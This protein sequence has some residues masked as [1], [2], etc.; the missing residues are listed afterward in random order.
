LIVLLL[1]YYVKQ[2]AGKLVQKEGHTV[3]YV[4]WSVYSGYFESIGTITFWAMMAAAV[5]SI[6]LSLFSSVW[7]G[8]WAQGGAGSN[9]SV[10]FYISIYVALSISTVFFVY[11]S[12]ALGFKGAVAASEKMH[13]DF[14]HGLMRAPIS[15][16]DSTPL[17][18]ITNRLSKD[19]NQVDTVIMFNLQMFLRAALG[20]LGTLVIIGINTTYVL[21]PFIPLLAIFAGIQNYFR[22]TSVQLKRLEAVSRSPVYAHFSESLGG[23]ATIRAFLA[24]SRMV[25]ENSLKLD[26]NQRIYVMVMTANR[27]LSIRLE[28]LGALLILATA[29]NC[30]ILRNSLSA[31]SAGIAL[32]YALQ[33][34]AQLNLLVRMSTEMESSFNAVERVQVRSSCCALCASSV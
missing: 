26:E 19:I 23:M 27:W 30:V 20:L 4:K 25:A 7:L 31:S 15:F 6:A 10:F 21:V 18:R 1:L 22:S 12:N 13:A 17:G 34:T 32:A 5:V 29:V 24:Q 14:V 28:F 11:V 2:D 8:I 16:F 3:G 9:R 33:I